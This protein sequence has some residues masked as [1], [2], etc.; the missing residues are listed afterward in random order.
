[1]VQFVSLL[2]LGMSIGVSASGMSIARLSLDDGLATELG[3]LS[4]DQG[5]GY[6][7]F[8]IGKGMMALYDDVG[9]G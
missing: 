4:T 8:N 7:P 2:A 9:K 3:K 1:M 5:H 6:S